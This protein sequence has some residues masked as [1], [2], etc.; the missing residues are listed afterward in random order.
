MLY[1]IDS[2]SRIT[3]IPHKA[4]YD[5]WRVG[6]SDQEYDAIYSELSSRISGAEIETSSWI[7]GSDWFGTVYQPI[8]DKACHCNEESAAKFFGLILWHVV[9]EHEEAWS[10]GRYR[11]GDMPIEGLTYFRIKNPGI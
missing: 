11:L 2:N 1:S 7:P 3:K 10:F 5:S 9:M 4:D 6:I 8:Y